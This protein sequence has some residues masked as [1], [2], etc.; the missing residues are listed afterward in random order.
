[1][2]SDPTKRRFFLCTG[3]IVYYDDLYKYPASHILGELRYLTDEGRR[4]TAMAMWDMPVSAKIVPPLKP[5][6]MVYL[7][8][9]AR[10]IRCRFEGCENQQRWEIGQP[11][12]LALLS[13]YGIET[14]EQLEAMTKKEK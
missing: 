11:A 6:I 10:L 13:H 1:M 7:I 3:E 12:F 9:D 4:V 14:L 2:P 8:G 5:A